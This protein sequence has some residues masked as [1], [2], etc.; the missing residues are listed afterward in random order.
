M[1]HS[2]YSKE[3]RNID[4]STLLGFYRCF[5]VAFVLCDYSSIVVVVVVGVFVAV[6]VIAVVNVV[7]IIVN[8]IQYFSLIQKSSGS[9]KS[10]NKTPR[11]QEIPE[12]ISR[13]NT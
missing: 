12:K 7:I 2:K 3:C 6:V 8:V 5:I 1:L 10:E 13:S 4:P 11:Y 9:E